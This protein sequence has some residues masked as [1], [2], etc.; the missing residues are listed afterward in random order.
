MTIPTRDEL[1]ERADR[2]LKPWRDNAEVRMLNEMVAD[3][4]IAESAS[5]VRRAVREELEALQQDIVHA[6]LV[7]SPEAAGFNQAADMHALRID[8]RLA[9]LRQAEH[10]NGPGQVV[11]SLS[12]S[13]DTTVLAVRTPDPASTPDDI[14]RGVA[15][16][17]DDSRRA[18]PAR[19][20]SP[21]PP[22]A[23][24][25][26]D[27]LECAADVTDRL[28]HG[29][30]SNA[31]REH[32]RK[33]RAAPAPKPVDVFEA[34]ADASWSSD[35]TTWGDDARNWFGPLVEALEKTIPSRCRDR[36]GMDQATADVIEADCEAALSELRRKAQEAGQ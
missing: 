32:A 30:V 14:E 22:P 29:F 23:L 15:A 25:D 13:A 8:A 2:Y 28:Q 5:D 24:S 6:S 27:K 33:L 18:S 34:F 21:C 35:E 16:A 1:I 11:E 17:L 10:D 7:L 36:H 31:L 3:F 4:A 12:R 9:A 19:P 26:A 20:S